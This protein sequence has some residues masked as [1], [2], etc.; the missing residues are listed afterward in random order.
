MTTN[1]PLVEKD[2]HPTLLSPVLPTGSAN[3]ERRTVRE[4]L[5]AHAAFRVNV[6]GR[7]HNVRGDP[8]DGFRAIV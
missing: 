1:T 5:I 2:Q 3:R 8:T 6:P 4:C 7:D